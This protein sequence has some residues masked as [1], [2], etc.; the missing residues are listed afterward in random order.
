[1]FSLLSFLHSSFF[2]FFSELVYS[3]LEFVHYCRSASEFSG[4]FWV[5]VWFDLLLLKGCW[6]E[7]V[8]VL[9]Q[10]KLE[11]FISNFD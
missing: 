5:E 10:L 11:F 7:V 4:R 1:M 6:I 2:Y 3:F 9:W 8:F